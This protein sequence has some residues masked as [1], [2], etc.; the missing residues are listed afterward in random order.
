MNDR[1]FEEIA[2]DRFWKL[3][4]EAEELIIEGIEKWLETGNEYTCPF[5][6]LKKACWVCAYYF[7][8]LRA[9]PCGI[10]SY[11]YVRKK[12]EEILDELTKEGRKNE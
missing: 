4:K 9:C 5:I 3:E 1:L 6:S 11:G 12:A 7:G 10:Y 8:T 2:K